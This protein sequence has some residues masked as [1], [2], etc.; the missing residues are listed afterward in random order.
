MLG[1]SKYP[2]PYI[3]QCRARFGAQL[4]AYEALASATP[5][6][7]ATGAFEPGF[8]GHMLMALEMSFVHRL[9]GVEGKDGN[10]LNEA[11]VLCSSLLLHEG[12]MT[13]EKSIKLKPDESL[14]GYREGDRIELTIPQL[15]RLSDAFF[16]ELERRFS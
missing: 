6:A 4:D 10:P 7:D 13:P 15:R 12:V 11:R 9:R 8:C 14:L 1:V 2:K 5:A 16:A 3:E